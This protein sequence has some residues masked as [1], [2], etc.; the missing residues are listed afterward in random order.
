MRLET[1]IKLLKVH[2]ETAK[3]LEWVHN[4]VAFALYQTWRMADKKYGK[5]GDE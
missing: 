5:D 2:Y 1:A 3:K 4:P